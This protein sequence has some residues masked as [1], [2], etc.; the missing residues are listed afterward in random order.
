MKFDGRRDNRVHEWFAL[1]YSNYLILPRSLMQAMPIEW[2]ER[3]T[4]CLKEMRS[5]VEPLQP[6]NDNYCV[7]LRNERGRFIEDPYSEY[8][9]SRVPDLEIPKEK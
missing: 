9:H 6:I 7:Q 3:L 8:R 1:T 4:A 2:Q 5:A